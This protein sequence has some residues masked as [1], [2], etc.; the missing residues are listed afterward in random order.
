MIS[1][2]VSLDKKGFKILYW[3]QR[4]WKSQTLMCRM[5]PKASEYAKSFK[6][7]QLLKEYSKT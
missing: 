1:K 6:Y 3:L 7:D 2:K 4:W 5:L